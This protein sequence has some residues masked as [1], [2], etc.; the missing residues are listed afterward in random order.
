MNE[1][2]ERV[3][4]HVVR[5]RQ[6][7]D[8]P[9]GFAGRVMAHVRE[10][11]EA[12]LDGWFVRRVALPFMAG[13]GAASAGLGLAWLWLWQAGYAGELTLLISGATW[14]GF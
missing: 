14:A 9:P 11:A 6:T 5:S 10:R 12:A 8:V 1:R 13:G 3:V 2:M 7:V 4:G